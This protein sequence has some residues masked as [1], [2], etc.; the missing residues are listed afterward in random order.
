MLKHERWELAW[1]TPEQLN[2]SRTVRTSDLLGHPTIAS[3]PAVTAASARNRVHSIL[4]SIDLPA[5]AVA[6][7]CMLSTG[8][9]ELNINY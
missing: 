4:L 7:Q 2:D 1:L 9:Q 5:T 8:S 3:D 6:V